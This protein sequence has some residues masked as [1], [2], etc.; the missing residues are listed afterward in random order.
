MDAVAVKHQQ[1]DLS[2]PLSEYPNNTFHQ[3]KTLVER[4]IV[5]TIKRPKVAITG[6]FRNLVI[7][8]FLGSIYYNL[9]TGTDASDYS[10]RLALLFFCLLSHFVSHQEVIPMMGQEQL[11]YYRERGARAYGALPYWISIWAVRVPLIALYTLVFSLAVYNLAGLRSGGFGVFFII[12][13]CHST[14][15]S[16]LCQFI[17]AANPTTAMAIANMSVALFLNIMF[18]GFIIFLDD[19]PPVLGSWA[20]Y[21]SFFRFSYQVLPF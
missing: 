13:F 5:K 18:A 7:G 11:L 1:D 20:P 17:A 8:S 3:I 15:A 2:S 14:A 4:Q 16:F 9:P 6:L 19:L 10:N 21:L 12:L